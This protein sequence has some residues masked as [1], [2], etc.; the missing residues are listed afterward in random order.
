MRIGNLNKAALSCLIAIGLVLSCKHP[1]SCCKQYS[2]ESDQATYCNRHKSAGYEFV[3]NDDASLSQERYQKL[4]ELMGKI[5]NCESVSCIELAIKGDSSLSRL[6]S[7]YTLEHTKA[8]ERTHLTE[9]EK[10]KLILCGFSNALDDIATN[11]KQEG[12]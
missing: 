8:E 3:E 12:K 1:D 5:Q 11:I 2:P 6:D 10:S 9:S 4:Q 7:T